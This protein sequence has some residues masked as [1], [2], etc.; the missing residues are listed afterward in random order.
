[1]SD[2]SET[3]KNVPKESNGFFKYITTF[4]EEQKGELMNMIQYS[5]LA[6]IPVIIILRSVKSLVPEEDESKGCLELSMECM[7][8]II[9][10][11]VMIWITNRLI[12]YVP[13]YS[14]VDY[15]EFSPVNFILPFL[16]ILCTMQSKLGYKLNIMTDRA[17]D[18]WHG[19]TKQQT[20]SQG[21][22]NGAANG[23]AN[24]AAG[25]GGGNPN[26]MIQPQ[27]HQPS[28][29]DYLDTNNLLPSNPQ[30]SSM[31]NTQPSPQ[32]MA[33]QQGPDFNSMYQGPNTPLVNA[34]T[35]GQ[36]GMMSD[37]PMAANE[38]LGGFSSW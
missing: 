11:M 5:I 12:R 23:S 10:V 27:Q 20:V 30:M 25:G 8:Q 3:V 33:M 7:L 16:I 15:K 6:I 24:G 18:M 22:Q 9:F 19:N 13:T 2:L 21:Q 36:E 29:A 37:G 34:A 35:P 31:P 38:A 28:Q 32:Q 26:F 17:M 4:E 1:M 14:G